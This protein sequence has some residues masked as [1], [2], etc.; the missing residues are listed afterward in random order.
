[1]KPVLV[2]LGPIPIST[3]GVFLLLAFV[4]GLA[5]AR[6]RARALG[7]APAQMLDVGLYVI[8][9]GILG[10][11]IGYALV[12]LSTFAAEPLR[13][14]ALWRDAGLVFSGAVLGGVVVAVAAARGLRVSPLGFLDALAPGAAVGV[15]VAT[16][17]GWMH[18]LFVGR[19]TGVP[20]A[21]PVMLEMRHPAAIYLLLAAVGICAVLWAQ[22]ART[23][24]AGT[25]FFLWLLLYGVTRGA[26][27]FFIDS[28]TVLG[29]L[30]LAHLSSAAAA[31]VG[32]AGLVAV[33]RR[34][35]Y[36]PGAPAP[37]DPPRP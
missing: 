8:I 28:P 34:T 37:D 18:G 15:A 21:V 11:R 5:V 31:A 13:L 2:Q 14:L 17:G 26:V 12:N 27:E 6:G 36:P 33:S 10:G 9:G 20:W 22:D 1:M 7:V 30:T 35:R 3:F 29:P 4:A 32:A 25:L 16:V 19:P 24:P 23:T